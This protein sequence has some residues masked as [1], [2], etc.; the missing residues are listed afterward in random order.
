MEK[1]NN[2]IENNVDPI[3]NKIDKYKQPINLNTIG[4]LLKYLEYRREASKRSDV[5]MIYL[6]YLN[7]QIKNLLDL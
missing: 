7:E 4:T 5:T 1:L 3:I 6:E 2:N